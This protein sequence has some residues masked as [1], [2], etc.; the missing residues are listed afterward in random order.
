MLDINVTHTR[1]R[2]FESFFD[3]ATVVVRTNKKNHIETEATATSAT[4]VDALCKQFSLESDTMDLLQRIE[5][6]WIFRVI[7][8]RNVYILYDDEK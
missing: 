7:A 3:R 4:L 5:F 8:W 1:S 2:P 6:E